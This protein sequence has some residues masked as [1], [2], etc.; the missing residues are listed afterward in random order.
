MGVHNQ[1]KEYGSMLVELG[2]KNPD[3]VVLEADLGKSTMSCMFEEAFPDRYFEMGIAEQNMT[4]FAGGLALAGKV[5][6]TN[7]FAV[8]AS[9]R[10]YDQ[11]R[12]LSLIHI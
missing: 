2:K 7:T 9:G 6:F 8:F 3:I 1:R 10:A 12:Q 11:I 4:S 5:P